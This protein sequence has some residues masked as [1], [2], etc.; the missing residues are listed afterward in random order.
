[1]ESVL[2][3]FLMPIFSGSASN[4]SSWNHLTK[5]SMVDGCVYGICFV[6]QLSTLF[7]FRNTQWSTSA[8]T[9]FV[10]LKSHYLNQWEQCSIL[11]N[12]ESFY[13][14]SIYEQCTTV[15]LVAK[16][17]WALDNQIPG[18]RWLLGLQGLQQHWGSPLFLKSFLHRGSMI[19]AD[20][21]DSH[22][23]IQYISSLTISGLSYVCMLGAYRVWER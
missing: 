22:R 21:S 3:V 14:P 7:I 6:R 11:E 17:W 20:T 19:T 8:N 23:Y 15:K 5:R 4:N 9:C 13:G 18:Q 2:K 10:L 16:W 1:M 12:L